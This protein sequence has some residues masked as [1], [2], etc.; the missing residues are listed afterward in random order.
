MKSGQ[1]SVQA[2]ATPQP[3]VIYQSEFR[4]KH[5][6]GRPAAVEVLATLLAEREDE[7]WQDF[8]CNEESWTVRWDISGFIDR[9][10]NITTTLTAIFSKDNSAV[11][12]LERHIKNPAGKNISVEQEQQG[13]NSILATIQKD[14]A[15][16]LKERQLQK[17]SDLQFNTTAENDCP[18]WSKKLYQKF[19]WHYRGNIGNY[20]WERYLNLSIHGLV[21]LACTIL[22]IF[23][24]LYEKHLMG[25]ST[26]TALRLG[27]SSNI[28]IYEG[29]YFRLFT[30][31]F[32]H[33]SII[34]FIYNVMIYVY[35][36]N[37]F[38]RKYGTFFTL[39]FLIGAAI[40]PFA[41]EYLMTGNKLIVS[42]GISSILTA[43]LGLLLTRIIFSYAGGIK[44]FLFY[45]VISLSILFIIG[46]IDGGTSLYGHISGFL[47][48]ICYGLIV[49]LFLRLKIRAA[50]ITTASV[51]ALSLLLA[52]SALCIRAG[53]K[54]P[55]IQAY[56]VVKQAGAAQDSIIEQITAYNDSSLI[57]RRDINL[58]GITALEGHIRELDTLGTMKLDTNFLNSVNKL[59]D[60]LEAEQAYY[61]IYARYF[62]EDSTVTEDML[63]VAGQ[64]RDSLWNVYAQ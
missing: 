32:F 3:E 54:N 37:F 60:F 14:Y 59:K 28:L 40:F 9:Q 43:M 35:A 5:E 17:K 18:G 22:L 29:E 39:S 53:E 64:L 51:F 4:I 36:G 47:A 44:D 16:R 52:A 42:G 11:I 56:A 12:C 46:F 50:N 63:Q 55:I 21:I 33:F 25:F 10:N 34:H 15:L 62:D 58:N 61:S 49:L 2:S 27:A 20:S 19:N 23:S 57:Q 8:D 31:S 38:A 1:P 30:G 6:M 13:L 41:A 48:G 45:A 24:M 26:A 7:I